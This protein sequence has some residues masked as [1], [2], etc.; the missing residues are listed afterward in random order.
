MRKA[1]L[2]GPLGARVDQR[3]QAEVGL[4]H[5]PVE[6]LLALDVLIEVAARQVLIQNERWHS[7]RASPEKE[8]LRGQR[9]ARL[10]SSRCIACSD[11]FQ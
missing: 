7:R 2:Q 11:V 1:R 6:S 8:H 5:V 4:S 3:S 10:S 9:R